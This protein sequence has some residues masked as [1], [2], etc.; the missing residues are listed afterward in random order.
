MEATE[1]YASYNIFRAFNLRKKHY[2]NNMLV[3]DSMTSILGMLSS[4]TKR[5]N[6]FRDMNTGNHFFLF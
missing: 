4:V 6:C 2:K 5:L 3:F 1:R